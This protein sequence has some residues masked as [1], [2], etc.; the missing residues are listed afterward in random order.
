MDDIAILR[1]TNGNDFFCIINA[2]LSVESCAAV[3]TAY[4]RLGSNRQSDAMPPSTELGSSAR[5][6]RTT[7]VQTS[8]GVTLKMTHKT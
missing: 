2:K 3:C 5:A 4:A 8:N 6:P 7:D 1:V